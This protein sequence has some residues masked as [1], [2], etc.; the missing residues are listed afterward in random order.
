[1]LKDSETKNE[2]K[3]VV[4]GDASDAVK[5]LKKVLKDSEPKEKKSDTP[6]FHIPEG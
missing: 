4:S 3:K 1:V 6:A 5:S 2:E